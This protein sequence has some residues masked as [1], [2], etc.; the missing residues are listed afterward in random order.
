MIALPIALWRGIVADK[1][2]AATQEHQQGL[3]KNSANIAQRQGKTAQEQVKIAQEQVEAAQRKPVQRNRVCVTNAIKRVRRCSAVKSYLSG[4]G[5][6]G[7][8]QRLAVNTPRNTTSQLC[9]LFCA[10]VRNPTNDEWYEEK[11]VRLTGKADDPWIRE[12]VQAVMTA[13]GERDGRRIRLETNSGYTLELSGV[14]LE[15]ALIPAA[16]ESHQ[17]RSI[18]Q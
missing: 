13:I 3:H 16:S 14:N 1:Q 4:L 7:T 9:R 6:I 12:D 15:C 17:C 5:G 10:F 18:E 2:S 11:L 8:L